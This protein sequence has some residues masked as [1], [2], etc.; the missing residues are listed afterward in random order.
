MSGP[1]VV[2]AAPSAGLEPD[3]LDPEQIL[4]GDPRTFDL[5][6]ARRLPRPQGSNP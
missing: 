5:E 2:G 4:G 3:P 6:L 1:V